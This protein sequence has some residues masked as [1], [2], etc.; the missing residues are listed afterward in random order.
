MIKVIIRSL[1]YPWIILFIGFSIGFICNS[2]YVGEKAVVVEKSINN[3]FFP[4]KYD[5]RV[6]SLVKNAG[7]M[8][9][10]ASLGC[11]ENFE[12]I[13]EVVKG[14]EYYWAIYK[15]KDKTGKEIKDIGSIKVKWKTWEYHYKLD[16]IIEADGTTKKLD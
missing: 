4:I 3:I 14:E 5:E 2:E 13:D 10:W 8:R 6:E 12:V 9:L 16:E 1:L 11:P 7:R 15:I